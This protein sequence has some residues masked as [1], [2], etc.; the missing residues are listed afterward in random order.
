[1]KA[2]SDVEFLMLAIQ[3]KDLMTLGKYATHGI[4]SDQD[5]AQFMAQCEKV[6]AM[7]DKH[8]EG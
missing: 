3:V 6:R 7:I 8:L 2:P 5:I 4:A 1:M